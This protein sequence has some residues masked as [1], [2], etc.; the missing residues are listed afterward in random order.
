MRKALV[1]LIIAAFNAMPVFAHCP[2]CTVGA[3]AAAGGALWLGVSP[4]VVSVFIGAFAAAVG[5]WFARVIKKKFFLGQDWLIV[6]ASFVTT[7]LPILSFVKDVRPWY[8]SWFGEYG[9]VF[10]RTYVVNVSLL[11]SIIGA[12]LVI[13]APFLSKKISQMRGKTVKFQGIVLTF[14]LLVLFGLVLW[15]L[16]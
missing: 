15:V 8:I 6:I 7:V 9:S 10:N 16:L 2:L 11:T 1:L 4:A 3:A 5:L 14:L 13:V 12:V